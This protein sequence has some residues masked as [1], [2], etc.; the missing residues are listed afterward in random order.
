MYNRYPEETKR[1]VVA[2]IRAGITP[3]VISRKTGI[4]KITAAYWSNSAAYSDV[5]AADGEILK[6][7]SADAPGMDLVKIPCGNTGITMNQDRAV[8][9]ITGD[10]TIE[11]NQNMSAGDLVAIINALRG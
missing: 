4:P 5:P 1:N 11:L 6:S 9:I 10:L 7:L 2:A 3:G 8:R